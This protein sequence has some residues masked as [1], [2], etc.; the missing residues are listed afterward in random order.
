[1]NIRPRAAKAPLI[2]SNTTWKKTF[3]LAVVPHL[4]TVEWSASISKR[5]KMQPGDLVEIK[6]TTIGVPTGTIGLV[7]EGHTS[8]GLPSD[9]PIEIWIVQLLSGKQRRYLTRDLKKIS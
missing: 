7:V 2:L 9:D 1:M 5:F 3:G 8:H 6:R 4:N